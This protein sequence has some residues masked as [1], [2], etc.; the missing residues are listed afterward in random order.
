ML[1]CFFGVHKNLQGRGRAWRAG[2]RTNTWIFLCLILDVQTNLIGIHIYLFPRPFKREYSDIDISY[3]IRKFTQECILMY[4]LSTKLLDFNGSI[5]IS[6]SMKKE[7]FS[8]GSLASSLEKTRG[9]QLEITL[10]K[11]VPLLCLI[12]CLLALVFSWL[13]QIIR[14]MF[15]S[16]KN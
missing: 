13:S 2:K 9:D 8:D 11:V 15:Q 5:F 12:T 16:T 10:T 3:I 6:C 14:E 4:S 1:W 7:K